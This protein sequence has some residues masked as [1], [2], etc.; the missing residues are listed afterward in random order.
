MKKIF[1]FF[2]RILS[3]FDKWLITPVTK[4]ILFISDLT[5]NNGKEIEKFI[6]KKQ[7][8]IV[9]S[10]IFA[11]IVFIVVDQNSNTIINKKAEILYNQTVVA[12]YNQEA[13]VIEGLPETVDI[14]LIGRQSDLYL[15][16]QYPVNNVSV[17][18]R[19]LKPGSH[20]V[21]LK[22]NQQL[23][24]IDYKIDPSTA[25]IVI[26]EKVSENR[27]LDYDVLH[28]DK[29]DKKLVIDGITLSRSDVIIK[30]AEYKLKTV[31]NVKALIDVNNISNP[32]TGDIK[33]TDIPLVAYD[34][35]GNPVDVE[36]VPTT[37]DATIKISSPSKEVPIEV[38]PKGDLAFGK[39]IKEIVPSISKVTIYGDKEIVDKITS[40]PVEIDVSNLSDDKSYNINLKKPSGIRDI[41]SKTINIKVTLDDVVTKELTGINVSPVNLR[42]GLKVQ[43]ASE[44]DSQVTAIVKGSSGVINSLD[45]SS[46]KAIIDLSGY[47]V[48]EHN[49]EVKVTGT[50]VRLTYESKVKKVKVLITEK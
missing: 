17:D 21:K 5:K 18:L 30:G 33:L 44:S 13:Y 39:S 24:S 41:S 6:N 38:V 34:E 43:A 11:F 23:S 37:V 7:T 3:F 20:K 50:D 15:A 27:E 22:Y 12:E 42:D 8:L 46:I 26:Y 4:G 40:I 28:K 1:N 10:L 25:T 16:K 19:G 35:K 31:A 36:I 32:T 9:L 47:D 29:L 2:R 14:T 45:P 49:V 48:G